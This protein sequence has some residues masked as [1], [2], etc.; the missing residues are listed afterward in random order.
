MLL[1][2]THNIGFLVLRILKTSKEVEFLFL[3][4]YSYLNLCK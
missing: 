1:L 4:K 2:G 3:N